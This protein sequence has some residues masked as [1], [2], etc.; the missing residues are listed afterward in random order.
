M[1]SLLELLHHSDPLVDLGPLPDIGLFRIL[2]CRFA[3][4]LL[5]VLAGILCCLLEMLLFCFKANVLEL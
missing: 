5:D 3:D 4:E 1:D 2:F